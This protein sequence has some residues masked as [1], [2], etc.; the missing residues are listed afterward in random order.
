MGGDG[1]AA[2]PPDVADRP[3]G[4]PAPRDRPIDANREQIALAGR[5]LLADE[6]DG[7][8]DEAREPAGHL[9]GPDVAVRSDRDRVESCPLRLGHDVPWRERGGAQRMRVHVKVDREHLIAV[10]DDIGSV[11]RA[12]AAGAGGERR[13]EHGADDEKAHAHRPAKNTIVGTIAGRLMTRRIGIHD[14]RR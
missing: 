13:R 4:A 11:G 8:L 6:H 7:P 1:D 9:R 2:L 14:S 3:R 12:V 5:D 10:Q